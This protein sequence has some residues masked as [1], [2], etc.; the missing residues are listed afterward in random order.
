M[1]SAVT[2]INIPRMYNPVKQSQEQDPDGRFIRQWLP[3]LA[4]VPNE[5]IHTP[6]LM[7]AEQQRQ[8]GVRL[9]SDYPIPLMDHEAAA[10]AAKA[11]L[12]AYWQRPD[13]A[14]LSALVL[15][16]HGSHRRKLSIGAKSAEP[17]KRAI[18]K[19]RQRDLFD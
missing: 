1:Q 16:K 14:P 18:L 17:G 2:G 5:L 4:G 7:H 6:W 15:K 19:S 3:E 11:K 8:F 9:D 10:R 13:M 12:S